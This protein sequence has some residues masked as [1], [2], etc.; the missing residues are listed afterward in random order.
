[1]GDAHYRKVGNKGDVWKHFILCSV[2]EELI[3]RHIGDRPFVYLDSHCS[4]GRFP[5]YPNS[6][7]ERGIGTLYDRDWS[8]SGHPYLQIERAAYAD[9]KSYLGSWEIVRS[10]ARLHNVS[11]DLRL[12]DMSTE[13]AKKL[14]DEKGFS[15]SD[16]FDAVLADTAADL[17]LI[18]PAYSEHRGADWRRTKEV[19]QR[20]LAQSATALIWYPI[21]V[22]EHTLQALTG[23]SIAEVRWP[24]N[25]ANQVMRGCGV[26]ATG[27]AATITFT[28]QDELREVAVALGGTVSLIDRSSAK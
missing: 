11:S 22:K 14:R 26:I 28:L 7:W 27:A 19:G 23:C 15:Q 16:G 2:A 18:D 25:G 21:Y 9:Q 6:E 4:T 5:L 8:L 24:A 12:F 10:L 1:M 13:V 3:S 17:S 20:L